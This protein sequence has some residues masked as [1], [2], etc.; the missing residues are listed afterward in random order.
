MIGPSARFFAW[1][2]DAGFYAE[3]HRVAVALVPPSGGRWLDVGCGPGL[4]AGL[5]ADAGFDAV[6]V[7]RDPD[8][9]RLA[10]R[11]HRGRDALRFETGDLET[12]VPCSADVVSAASLLAALPEPRAGVRRLWDAV[13]PGGTLLLVE[14][15]E[16]MTP[17]RAGRIA[18]GLPPHG[19]VALTLW[20]H[21]R[22]GRAVDLGMLSNVGATTVATTPMLDGLVAATVLTKPG[23]T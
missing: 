4:V 18:A 16:Q 13:R 3:L 14:T 6:G 21:A 19:R 1:V 23:A 17:D 15:T 2:Q 22:R 11:R 12:I 8:M 10:E 20:S 9:V 5:A 7:D